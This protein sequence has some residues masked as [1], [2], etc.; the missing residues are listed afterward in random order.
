MG[1]LVKIGLQL[2]KVLH[3]FGV[4]LARSPSGPEWRRTRLMAA[5]G[6][7]AV[8]DVGANEGQYGRRLRQLGY[9]GS[10]YSYEPLPAAFARLR[11]CSQSD[12]RWRAFNLAVGD[13]AG[14]VNLNVA[15]NS[16]SSSILAITRSHLDA[17]PRSE[18]VA[19]VE[20]EVT[21]L[22][23]IVKDLPPQPT[24]LK[25]DTQ[26]YEDRVLAGGMGM[27][28]R[29]HLLEVELSLFEVY[30]GQR[31]FRDMDARILA[32]GFELVSL[33]EGFF[34]RHTGQLLQVD[35]IYARREAATSESC[36]SR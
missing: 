2:N 7:T 27:L 1:A 25:I 23:D 18:T 21:T 31:L 8:I 36:A 34:D 16:E 35:A 12:Q 3:H 29:V 26:G 32:A 20:V 6:I 33:A 10:I 11:E 5:K 15:A 13:A 22:D 17:E 24:M 9:G 19:S 30:S 28:H 14:R 4:Q